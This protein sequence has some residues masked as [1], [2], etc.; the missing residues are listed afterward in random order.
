MNLN[1]FKERNIMNIRKLIITILIFVL[2]SVSIV[3][4][5]EAY[6]LEGYH[7]PTN[8]TYWYVPGS[9]ISSDGIYAITLADNQW[10]NIQNKKIS[11]VNNGQRCLTKQF[12]HDGVN[13]IFKNNMGAGYLAET[14]SWSNGSNETEA[15]IVINVY[16]SISATT[17]PA[18]GSYHLTSMITH[19]FGHVA[20]LGHSTYST[21]VMYPTFAQGEVRYILSSDDI[22]GYNHIQ[23]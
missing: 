8:T 19:E 20:G 4:F 11:L 18:P 22:S 12:T 1:N 15:D 23:W 10:N 16:Y 13:E 17:P 5:A 2:C 6:S 21:A 14:Q 9:D 3:N 7:W